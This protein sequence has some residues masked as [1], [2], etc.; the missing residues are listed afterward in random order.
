M[1]NNRI[2]QLNEVIRIMKRTENELDS[3]QVLNVI[4][5]DE[6]FKVVLLIV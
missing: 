4:E 5:K 2:A 3:K 1:N 6:L